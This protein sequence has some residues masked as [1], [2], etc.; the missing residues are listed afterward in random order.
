MN[1]SFLFR[2]ERRFELWD[3]GYF[4]TGEIVWRGLDCVSVR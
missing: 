1:E 4:L 2:C 3:G